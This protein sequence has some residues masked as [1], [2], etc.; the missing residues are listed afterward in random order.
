MVC[1]KSCMMR[2]RA[3]VLSLVYIHIGHSWDDERKFHTDPLVF[4]RGRAL[5]AISGSRFLRARMVPNLTS[6]LRKQV[7]D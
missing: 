1:R 7:F 2:R 4:T 3:G 5:M 6:G